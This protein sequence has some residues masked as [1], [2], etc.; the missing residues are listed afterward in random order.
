[1]ILSILGMHSI[2]NHLTHKTLLKFRAGSWEVEPWEESE[3][4]KATLQSGG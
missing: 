2:M 4:P 3:E 1:M